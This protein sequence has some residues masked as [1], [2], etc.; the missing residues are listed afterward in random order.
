VT[1]SLSR[2]T[3]LDGVSLLPGTAQINFLSFDL[4]TKFTLVWNL[5]M[6]TEIHKIISID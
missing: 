4:C 1:V 3:L 2:R 6:A 5:D